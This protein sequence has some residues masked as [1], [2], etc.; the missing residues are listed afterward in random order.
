MRGLVVR[1]MQAAVDIAVTDTMLQRNSPLPAG[2]TGNAACVRGE[3]LRSC[4]WHGYRPVTWQHIPPI[5]VSN[6]ER[7]CQ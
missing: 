4:A 6:T 7:L 5:A 1:D 3:C 2:S